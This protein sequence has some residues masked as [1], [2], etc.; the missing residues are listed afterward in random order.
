MLEGL[1]AKILQT[2]IGKY[3][4]VDANKLSVGLLSGI[5]ELENLPVKPEAFNDN[6]L[7]FELK[8]GFLEKVKVNIS[9]NA[10][11]YTPLVLTADNLFVIV[12]PRKR[13]GKRTETESVDDRKLQ[14]LNDLENKWFKEV[15]FLGVSTSGANAEEQTS[16]FSILGTLAYLLKNIHVNL[17]RIHIRYEDDNSSIGIYIDSICIKNSEVD[18]NEG[19]DA[20]VANETGDKA[21]TQNDKNHMQKSC[22]V[23]NFC[24]YTDTSTIYS[25]DVTTKEEVCERMNFDTLSQSSTLKHIVKP[26]SLIAQVYRDMSLQPLRKRNKPRIRVSSILKEFH[27]HID[28]EQITYI[29]NML[30]L[31]YIHSNTNEVARPATSLSESMNSYTFTLKPRF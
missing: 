28:E 12:G 4:D 1:A 21:Q 23:N 14:R 9:L 22:E 25:E 10:L 16:Y 15:E 18:S 24:I 13:N 6:N 26:T 30:R 7:P 31:M 29:S 2:Y 3:V 27:L 17:N 20:T 8:I 5:V 19:T 11:R